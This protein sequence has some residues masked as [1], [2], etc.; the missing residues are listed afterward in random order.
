VWP[1]SSEPLNSAHSWEALRYCWEALSSSA[2]SYLKQGLFGKA[3][4]LEYLVGMQLTV[5]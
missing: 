3:D 4:A 2:G 1:H 5:K